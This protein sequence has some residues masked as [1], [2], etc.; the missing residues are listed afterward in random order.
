MKIYNA[1][2][3]N[4]LILTEAAVEEALQRSFDV[5]LHPRLGN[6]LFIYDDVCKKVLTELYHGFVSL[7]LNAKIL[8]QRAASLGC[9][10]TI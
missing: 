3:K 9:P 7:A 10:I 8:K 2:K 6:A 5:I 1:L 4:D